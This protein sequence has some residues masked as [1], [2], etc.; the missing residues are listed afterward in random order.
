VERPFE[1]DLFR[2]LFERANTPNKESNRN[3]MAD[4]FRQGWIDGTRR[5]RWAEI[6]ALQVTYP[7]RTSAFA[8]TLDL[9]E[10]PSDRRATSHSV[11]DKEEAYMEIQSEDM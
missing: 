11:A 5:Q 8:A 3:V 9:M 1:V 7:E 10:L 4:A 2:D 6:A